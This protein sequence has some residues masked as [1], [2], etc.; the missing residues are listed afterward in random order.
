MHLSLKTFLCASVACVCL[1]GC[2]EEKAAA[3]VACG[4]RVSSSSRLITTP[5]WLKAPD[6]FSRAM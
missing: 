6:A 1:A 2:S 4:R 3:P 5:S